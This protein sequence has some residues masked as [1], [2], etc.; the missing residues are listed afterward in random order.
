MFKIKY[1][2]KIFVSTDSKK[3]AKICE[4]EGIDIPIL[5]PKK[6]AQDN[7][8]SISVINHVL[9]FLK[10]NE[11][12]EP[13]IVLLLQPTSPFR[14]SK[15]IDRSIQLLK[16]SKTDSV[17]TVKE[18]ESTNN[19]YYFKNRILIPYQK[20]SENNYVKNNSK[21]FFPTGAVYA[22]WNDTLKNF[23]TIYGKKILPIFS[24]FPETIDIDNISDLF[25]AEMTMLHWK[26]FNQ[27]YN[28]S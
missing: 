16:K 21:L 12:Y 27:K 23:N 13:D 20:I 18:T 8:P 19:S 28:N 15:L 17:I 6:L 24:K 26:K 11:N 9:L 1:V 25:L 7:T 3:I 2:N 10:K 14:T 4:S 22:F 5:R